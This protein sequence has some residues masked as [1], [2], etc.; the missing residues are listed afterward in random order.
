MTQNMRKGGQLFEA[1]NMVVKLNNL[2]SGWILAVLFYLLMFG[3]ARLWDYI[4]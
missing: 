2:Q 4:M 1:S 3:I